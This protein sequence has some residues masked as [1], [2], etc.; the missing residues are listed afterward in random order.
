MGV[1]EAPDIATEI[2]H[3]ICAD[4]EDV[5]FY[6]DDIGCFSDS[7][8]EHLQLLKT[9]LQ[10]LKSVGFTINTLKC[11]WAVKETDLLGHWLT[12]SGIKP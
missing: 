9:V 2:M 11:E 1:S 10:R 7:W 5:E 12:P 4:M 8:D 6:M 3:D